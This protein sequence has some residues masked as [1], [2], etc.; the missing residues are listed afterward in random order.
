MILKPKNAWHLGAVLVFIAVSCIFFHPALKG[1]TLDAHDV[2]TWVG[3]S[4]EVKDYRENTGEQILWTNSM[5]SGMPSTQI[6]M[7]YEGGQFIRFIRNAFSLWLPQP[8]SFLFAFFISFYILACTLRIKP[9]FGALGAIGYG[10][11]TYLIV[12]I[13]AGHN[14]KAGALGYAPL[15]IAGFILAYRRKSWLLGVALSAIFM[16]M[17]MQ[18]NHL[19]I[20]YYFAFILLGLGI[21]ELIRYAEKKRLI[22]FAKVTG[23]MVLAYGLAVLMNIGNITGTE[24]YAKHTIRGGSD[25]A[26]FQE[27]DTTAGAQ[28]TMV[29]KDGKLSIDYITNWSYG[30]GETWTLLVPNFKGGESVA[31]GNNEDN[32]GYLK[33]VKGPY[34][35]FVS[36]QSQYFGNQPFTSG[37]VYAGALLVLLAIISLFYVKDRYKWALL[38][39]SF[40]AILLSWGKNL[41]WF[42]EFFVDYVPLYGSFRT[43]TMIL[44]I[45][46]IAIPLLAIMFLQRLYKNREEIAKNIKPFL[47][48]S[49]SVLVILLAMGF[50]PGMFT[51]FLSD[52]ES[53]ALADMTDPAMLAQY[54][55]AFAELEAVRTSVFTADVWRSFIFVL[56][57]AAAVFAFIRKIF[58]VEILGTILLVLALA[59]LISVNKRYIGAEEQGKGYVQWQESYKK[60]YPYAAGNAEEQIYAREIQTKPELMAEIEQSL[61]N[62]KKD[63]DADMSAGEKKRRLDWM[64]FRLL[65]RKT[66][67]R[68]Y[69]MNNLTSS[70]YTSYFHKSIGGYHGAKLSRYQDLIENQLAVN[71]QAV[72]NMLNMKYV[73][74]PI[75]DQRGNIVDSRLIQQ[76][77]GAMGNAWFVKE[78]KVVGNA[79][80]EMRALDSYKSFNM[81]VLS[82]TP[83]LINGQQAEGSVSLNGTEQVSFLDVKV[84]ADLQMK[85]DTTMIPMPFQQIKAGEQIAYIRDTMGLQWV[86]ADM[87][88]STFDRIVTLKTTGVEGFDPVREAIV[89]E[90]F[91]S[92]LATSYT[93]EGTIEMTSYHPDELVYTSNSSSEQLAVFSEIYYPIG[94][95]A[96][97]DDEEVPIRRV[98]YVL[99]GLDVPAGEHTIKFVYDLDSYKSAGLM[100]WLSSIGAI[101]FLAFALFMEYRNRGNEKDLAY[102]MDGEDEGVSSEEIDHSKTE[103]AGTEED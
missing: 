97:V 65:N 71:N 31:I 20:T 21:V 99:R 3:M 95:K 73:I 74:Q 32:K 80:E 7:V 75:P 26:E 72:Q 64:R 40:L 6:S 44:V 49:G 19:Q 88:D 17:E 18:A 39:V 94:W 69:E 48:V 13:E 96:F 25:L 98:N 85:I 57:G 16:G 87:I 45:V 24:E 15:L 55:D 84:N 8:I 56:L 22:K 38:A 50:A 86:F 91:A 62:Q 28:T 47:I 53:L 36:G 5:F 33:D 89:G 93:G 30:K 83:V 37:P 43:V 102:E 34:K 59:D 29:N 100:M 61:A 51:D 70:S 67:Y 76:N 60:T 92:D 58:E 35:P 9:L 52:R 68:V 78:A 14:T 12:I 23:A 42:T 101:L 11:S 77:N 27:P 46:E 90:D 54:E 63:F 10:F 41:M 79:M 1:Y 81:E 103:E 66:N 4:Q 82:V 2:K